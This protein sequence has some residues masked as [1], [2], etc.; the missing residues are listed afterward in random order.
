MRIAGL[1]R[2]PETDFFQTHPELGW[3]HTPNQQGFY[4][5][6][7]QQIPIKINAKGLRDVE[8]SYEK[9]Q[10]TF[11]MLVL[12]DSFVEAFQVPVE[13]T[14]PRVLNSRLEQLDHDF[15]VINAGFSGVG[16][17]YE[18]LFF[19]KEGYKYHPDLVIVGFFIN[20]LYENYRSK[21]ILQ[22]NGARRIEYAKMGP[23]A[24]LRRFLADRSCAYNYIGSLVPR[25]APK[26]A[27]ILMKAGLL[28]SQPLEQAQ[29][30]PMHWMAF[31]K[32]YPSEWEEAWKLTKILMLELAKET[33]KRN[34]RLVVISIPLKAQVYPDVWNTGLS[35]RDMNPHDWDLDKPDRVL[36]EFLR[37]ADIPFLPLLPHFREAASDHPALYFNRDGHWNQHGHEL[38]AELIYSWLLEEG[39][40]PKK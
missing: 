37:E 19:S 1:Y 18:L 22:D 26:V 11:R 15:E 25:Y 12:G 39:L 6:E 36:A 38:T 32:T 28:S 33:R 20:D 30:A 5:V 17:D 23:I 31:A 3:I 34:A 8:H 40:I 21:E 35:E 4:T 16:T 14:F 24:R 29:K 2:F 7:G 13:Q 27:G 10:G 9:P